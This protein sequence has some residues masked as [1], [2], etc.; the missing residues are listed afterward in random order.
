MKLSRKLALTLRVAAVLALGAALVPILAAPAYAQPEPA[1]QIVL[2]TSCGST[3]TSGTTCTVTATL[4]DVD[5]NV[6]SDGSVVT[7][8]QGGSDT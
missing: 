7:F 2:T 4:E 1:R 6:V 5:D 3:L 8:A